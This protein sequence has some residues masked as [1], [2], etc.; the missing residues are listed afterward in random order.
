MLIFILQNVVCFKI[1][2]KYEQLGSKKGEAVAAET[3]QYVQKDKRVWHCLF[4]LCGIVYLTIVVYNGSLKKLTMV[5]RTPGIP[6]MIYRYW[7]PGLGAILAVQR[8][9]RNEH[10]SVLTR[11]KE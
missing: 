5:T 11:S 6:G 4:F 1:C 9:N 8:E 2:H 7:L 10:C 3:L